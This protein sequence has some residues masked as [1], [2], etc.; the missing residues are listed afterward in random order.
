MWNGIIIPM[1]LIMEFFSKSLTK[2][3]IFQFTMYKHTGVSESIDFDNRNFSNVK[4]FLHCNI[5]FLE[6]SEKDHTYI[7]DILTLY[8][9]E[10]MRAISIFS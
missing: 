1:L 5:L 2:S 7:S 9:N 6:C 8:I 10:K 3:Y 4:P